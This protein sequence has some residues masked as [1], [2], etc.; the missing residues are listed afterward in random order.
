MDRIGVVGTSHRTTSV[1]SLERATLPEGFA[2]E[3]LVELARLSGF[4]ELVYLGTCNR[5]ELHF[6]SS[7][8][9]RNA[10]ILFHLR[11][12]LADLAG[13]EAELPPDEELYILRGEEA[14]R[15][16]FRVTAA[17]DSMM[18]GEV[19]I[20]A[21][22]KAAHEL[23][24]E[25]DLLGG[26]LDQCFHEA[27]HV[28]KR[29]RTETDLARRPVSLVSLVERTLGA[30]LAATSTPVLVLG[31]GEMARETLRLV[32]KV[33]GQRRVLVANRSMERAEAL[34]EGDPLAHA[35]P[36]DATLSDPPG[37]GTVVAVTSS[38][39]VLLGVPG[40]EAIRRQLPAD[41]EL[42]VVDLALPANVDPAAGGLDG[43]RYVGIEAMRE[44][45]EANR[46]HRLAEISRCEAL[47]D[48][49]VEILRRRLLDRALSP[50]ARS[51]H[52]AYRE[53]AHGALHRTLSRELAHLDAPEREALER[54]AD[55]L[56]RRLVQIPLKGLKG[57]AGDHG[58]SVIES[59]HRRLE[60]EA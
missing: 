10:D 28:G 44:E 48:H 27:L 53:A 51:L 23:A 40:V 3:H 60:E 9:N 35:L 6:R 45:A 24:H 25:L 18:V 20:A 42:L 38:E 16:L 52:T 36:L 7:S 12:S 17:I 39:E 13:G 31:A 19:Q 1:A 22:V 50:V 15:H 34:V 14:A 58:A 29:I 37:A 2:R 5:V 30:H 59:F 21:Q 11:R 4:E 46:R 32:R 55:H 8:P 26:A 49:Q 43:V 56:V 33:D 47:I 57:A 54:F 41:E